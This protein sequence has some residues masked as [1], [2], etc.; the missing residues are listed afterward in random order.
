MRKITTFF[1]CM[2]LAA[3][4]I[5]LLAREC[6]ANEDDAGIFR[7]RNT[8]RCGG[9]CLSETG[10]ESEAPRPSL[11]SY[12]GRLIAKSINKFFGV[13]CRVN[14]ELENWALSDKCDIGPAARGDDPSARTLN[15][16]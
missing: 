8:C 11:V 14:Y 2:A 4:F 3:G 13:G 6:V 12:P 16:G 15:D 9:K 10:Y 5:H 1:V 7:E